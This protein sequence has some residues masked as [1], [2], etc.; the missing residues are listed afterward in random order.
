M[1]ND[2]VKLI[3]LSIPTPTISRQPMPSNIAA[4]RVCVASQENSAPAERGAAV[5]KC[6]KLREVKSGFDPRPRYDATL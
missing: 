3:P 2:M 6:A 1:N 5:S 4:S